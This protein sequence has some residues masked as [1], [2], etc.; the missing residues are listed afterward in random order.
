METLSNKEASLKLGDL[1]YA[2]DG[3][4]VYVININYT[5]EF[6]ERGKKL[7]YVTIKFLN[8]RREGVTTWT[9]EKDFLDLIEKGVYTYLPVKE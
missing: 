1:L 2:K 4:C 5:D 9:E 6:S 7:K 8:G 3:T